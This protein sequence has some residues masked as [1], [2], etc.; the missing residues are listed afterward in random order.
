MVF[1]LVI[2]FFVLVLL[3]GGNCRVGVGELFLELELLEELLR[4]LEK[5]LKGF[6]KKFDVFVGRIFFR[7]NLMLLFFFVLISYVNGIVV[8]VVF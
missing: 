2:G 5:W 6:N 7:E 1:F 3:I 4:E 8:N